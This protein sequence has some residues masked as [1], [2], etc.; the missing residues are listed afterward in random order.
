MNKSKLLKN[1]FLIFAFQVVILSLIIWV[2]NYQFN[3]SFDAGI[4]QIRQDIIQ[5]IANY[6]IYSAESGD[7]SGF[8]FI[9]FSWLVI[10][11]IPIF[12]YNDYKKAWSMNITT[13]FFPNFFFYVFLARY[14][15]VYSD[16]NFSTL[17]GQTLLLGVVLVVYSIGLSL[18]MKKIRK[19]QDEARIEDLQPI[20]DANRRR[21]PHCGTEFESVPKFCYK[22]S[23]EIIKFK[24]EETDYTEAIEAFKEDANITLE[25]WARSIDHLRLTIIGKKGTPYADGKFVFEIKLPENYPFQPPYAYAITDLRHPNIDSSIPPGKLNICLD[26]INPDLVGK[27]DASTGASGWTPSKTLTNLIDALKGMLH[28]EPPFFNPGD[29]LDPEAGEQYFRAQKK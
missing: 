12:I 6:V 7:L 17:F 22:C 9:Y 19:P 23:K 21:C 28:V 29:P 4:T 25:P 26:L 20:A 15:P 2:F 1:K 18:L 11:L 24:S 10:G 5:F 27:V 8:Y 3:I 16:A 14:S 13:F